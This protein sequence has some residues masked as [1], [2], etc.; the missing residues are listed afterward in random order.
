MA[1][2]RVSASLGAMDEF[3][4]K[5]LWLKALDT[6][7]EAVEA[8]TSAGLQTSEA[9]RLERRKLASERAWLETVDWLTL[10]PLAPVVGIDR[11]LHVVQL[12]LTKR[13]A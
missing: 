10:S 3:R 1:V 7:A 13:A 2:D 4:L 9:A 12:G 5:L 8:A 6:A 11:C